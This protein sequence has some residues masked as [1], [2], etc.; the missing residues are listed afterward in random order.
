MQPEQVANLDCLVRR[1]FAVRIP[2][3]KA[4][5]ARIIAAAGRLLADEDARTKARAFAVELAQWDGPQRS[6]QFLAA[7]FGGEG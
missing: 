5:A 2:K 1:G 3:R 4:N 7:T 6:A